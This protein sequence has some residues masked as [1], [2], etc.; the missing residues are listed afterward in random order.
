MNLAKQLRPA[1][2]LFVIL[3]VITG[4]IYPALMTGIAQVI[5]PGP[6]S[7]SLITDQ[8]GNIVGSALIGQ[9]FDAPEYFHPRPSSAG[10]NG[11]DA[12]SSSGSN[13][14][15]TNKTFIDGVKAN[16]DAY[17]QD[18]G[19]SADV[20]IPSD[21]VTGSGSGLDPEISPDNANLQVARVAKARGAS[22]D[23]IRGIVAQYTSG[24]TLGFLGDPRVNVLELNLALDQAF[25]KKAG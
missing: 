10:A 17:R 6:A 18:N 20:P 14:G 25:P 4:V 22:D 21:A 5:F 19:L 7:G 16:V 3:T 23:Q 2:V 9:N 1:M 15:P 24:R 12:S 11:Y 13:L 8:K